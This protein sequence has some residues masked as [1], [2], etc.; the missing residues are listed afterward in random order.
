M[1]LCLD[2]ENLKDEYS[3]EVLD[4]ISPYEN[5][6]YPSWLSL[7]KG[8]EC[9]LDIDIEVLETLIFP[10]NTKITFEVGENSGLTINPT[11]IKLDSL[12][13]NLK[14]INI[15]NGNT[16]E[17]YK[18]PKTIKISCTSTFSEHQQIK[19]FAE[20]NSNKVEVGKLMIYKNQE[21]YRLKARFVE[22]KFKGN[23]KSFNSVIIA[24]VKYK[25][26]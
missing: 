5:E 14:S 2:V 19:V 9:F 24:N 1:P 18:N 6:Y 21:L 13:N 7:K 25:K 4:S 23:I 8:N 20:L 3:N 26:S 17:L 10:T 22:V 12:I 11:S 16:K 15:G